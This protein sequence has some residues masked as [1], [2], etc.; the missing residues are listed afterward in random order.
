MSKSVS[1]KSASRLEVLDKPIIQLYY[2][3][4]KYL[5]LKQL[6]YYLGREVTTRSICVLGWLHFWRF[7]NFNK[8]IQPSVHCS[9]M[10]GGYLVLYLS[11][12]QKTI[13][14]VPS[15]SKVWAPWRGARDLWPVIARRIIN[16]SPILH[17]GSAV[18]KMVHNIKFR[19]FLI[20][21]I[22]GILGVIAHAQF[23]TKW[24]QIRTK[25]PPTI[26]EHLVGCALWN[27]KVDQN[28]ATLMCTHIEAI[29]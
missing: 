5:H 15:L 17:C 10:V 28:S 11:A 6:K 4:K 22:F 8:H 25:Y 29:K 14:V 20:L 24:T 16:I 7:S 3:T 9:P 2:D 19:S 1:W 27:S 26:C 18:S 13:Y 23:W 21:V 12:T